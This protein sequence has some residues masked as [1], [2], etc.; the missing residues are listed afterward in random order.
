MVKEIEILAN[1]LEDSSS[2]GTLSLHIPGSEA[3]SRELW[4]KLKLVD[5]EVPEL[6]FTIDPINNSSLSLCWH[7]LYNDSDDILAQAVELALINPKN[8]KCARK[9]SDQLKQ[10]L[11]QPKQYVIANISSETEFALTNGKGILLRLPKG[12]YQYII[13]QHPH[14]FSAWKAPEPADHADG[15]ISWTGNHPTS[16]I[17]TWSSH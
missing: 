6:K 13:L 12:E 9:L 8:G 11:N 16:T 15:T 17:K 3:P 14:N 10:R 7:P 5:S 2:L 4:V 1:Q